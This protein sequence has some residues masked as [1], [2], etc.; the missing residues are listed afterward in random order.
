MSVAKRHIQLQPTLEAAAAFQVV[1]QTAT[2]VAVVLAN[3][4]N[5]QSQM[6]LKLQQL[7]HAVYL[8]Y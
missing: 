1:T 6:L 4:T 3:N 8:F 5:L 2:N 7:L